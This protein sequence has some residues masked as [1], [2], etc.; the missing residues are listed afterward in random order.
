MTHKVHLATLVL[1]AG[2]SLA[3]RAQLLPA[4]KPGDEQPRADVT[5]QA[6][7]PG[8]VRGAP[9][10]SRASGP[11]TQTEDDEYVGRKLNSQGAKAV[12]K[13]LTPQGPLAA[14]S[15]REPA[16]RP[17]SPL[18]VPD[19]AVP[20]TLPGGAAPPGATGVPALPALPGGGL[21]PGLPRPNVIAPNRGVELACGIEFAKPC[22]EAINP[23]TARLQWG[24]HP[25]A[26]HYQV[27]RDGQL[28][29]MVEGSKGEYI[30]AD[31]RSGAVHRYRV[32]A[33]KSSGERIVAME[34]R[35]ERA[36]DGTM[37]ERSTDGQRS[38]RIPAGQ[39]VAQSQERSVALPALEPVRDLAAAV[40]DASTGRA[41][42]TW[43]PA[44]YATGYVL[45]RN[46]APL[47]TLGAIGS[48]DDANLQPGNH[49]YTVVTQFNPGGNRPPLATTPSNEAVVV[50]PALPMLVG[51]GISDIT[52]PIAEVRLMGYAQVGQVGGGLHTRL[53]AR[54]F[55]FADL[56]GSRRVVFVTA[57]LGMVFSSIK[58]GV[59]RRLQKNLGPQYSDSNVMIAATHTHSGP[60]GY[61][62]H[63]IF[64]MSSLGHVP[65]SYQAIVDGISEAIEAA[66]ASLAPASVSIAAGDVR[67]DEVAS[68]NRSETA[69]NSNLGAAGQPM[70]NP[71]MT[72]LRIDRN[73]KPVG[74]IA[75]FATHNTSI[76][77]DNRLICSDHKGL[78]SLQLERRMG[79]VSQMPGSNGFIAAF[80]NGDEGDMSPNIW[81]DWTQPAD[82]KLDEF[83]KMA[84]IARRQ[85]TTADR[86]FNGPQQPLRGDIDF[87]HT[88]VHMPGFAVNGNA[89]NG[90]GTN[91]LCDAGYGF[92]F[93]AGAEDGPSGMPYFKEGM[94][95]DSPEVRNA[96]IGLDAFKAALPA[97]LGSAFAD[98]QGAIA[99]MN[100]CQ[101]PKPVLIPT[102]PLGWGPTTLP[103]QIL[104]IG[105]VALVGI[106]GEMTVFAG[107]DLRNALAAQLAPLGVHTVVLT[108]LTNEYSGY[109]T[110]QQEYDTQQYEGAST[111]FGRLTFDAYKQIFGGLADAM[112][113]G[114]PVPP[115]R[116]PPDLSRGQLKLQTDVIYD[117]VPLGQRFGEVLREPRAP[118]L[119]GAMV[120]AVFRS[121]H[122][123]NDLRRNSTYLFVEQQSGSQ[124]VTVAVDADPE[125]R[126]LWTRDKDLLCKACSAVEVQWSIPPQA[127]P[128]IY[129]IRHVGAF[130]HGLTGAITPY[131]GVTKPFEVRR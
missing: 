77:Q 59:I 100:P 117:E 26:T 38:L 64:N 4:P 45:T 28:L 19:G 103:F 50:M 43:S 127:A 101:F 63:A 129:R 53:Y 30:D 114:Q 22:A 104:R 72:V 20:R 84:E 94:R 87:R 122:P 39:V 125:T 51:T 44:R 33:F 113:R 13:P 118:A 76:T 105:G 42:L 128:G 12:A 9:G 65:Q 62:H 85:L 56:Q 25:E 57:D 75:W 107:R 78:A 24:A 8:K 98:A 21:Q 48:Y 17:A 52:G 74:S 86:L 1:A 131:E 130:K 82:R 99:S 119:V 69:F 41:R 90:M 110:T 36:P 73:G 121:G 55:I 60:G 37:R 124:W 32:D 18:A 95:Q 106:P 46:G 5:R 58:Q 112:V 80:P 102:G 2:L 83:L 3:A 89:R 120:N 93:A 15:A 61:A 31:A 88:F 54:A 35:F 11:G 40:T 27:H 111:A 79:P 81:R 66:H 97:P 116:T 71:T 115:G 123:K 68:V 96:G 7:G 49:R 126:L 47:V 23:V 109:I 10:G 91:T 6:N 70:T 14:P 67:Q 92:S 108:G 16:I 29:G 34:P